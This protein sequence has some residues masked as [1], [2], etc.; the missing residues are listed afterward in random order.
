MGLWLIDWIVKLPYYRPKGA[1]IC[2]GFSLFKK[3][4]SEKH[5]KINSNSYIAVKPNVLLVF[6]KD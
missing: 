4:F 5:F 1:M 6:A 2:S 3:Y